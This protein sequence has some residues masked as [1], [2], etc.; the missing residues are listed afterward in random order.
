MYFGPL[1]SSNESNVGGQLYPIVDASALESIAPAATAHA[2]A[3]ATV[4][5]PR[6]PVSAPRIAAA[7]DV[8]AGH[9]AA[10]EPERAVAELDGLLAKQ[11]TNL[12]ALRQRGIALVEAG[13]PHDAIEDLSRVVAQ[14]PNAPDVHLWLGKAYEMKGRPGWALASFNS[15]L[16]LEPYHVEARDHRD[17]LVDVLETLGGAAFAGITP[18]SGHVTVEGEVACQVPSV[19]QRGA[20]VDQDLLI[21]WL[22][23]C[24]H[25]ESRSLLSFH[26]EFDHPTIH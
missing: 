2:R 15:V 1:G 5:T 19:D 11:P 25:P 16:R 22:V 4:S 10:D 7:L 26:F 20:Q 3:R 23:E 6:P 24:A 21:S 13:R 17:R 12:D 14:T 9:I 8:A 18:S